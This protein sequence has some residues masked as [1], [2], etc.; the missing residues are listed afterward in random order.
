VK[1]ARRLPKFIAASRDPPCRSTA[2]LFFF[3][4]LD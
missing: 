3:S 2:F 4:I 1:T